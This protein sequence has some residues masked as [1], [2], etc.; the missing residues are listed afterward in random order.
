[1]YNRCPS[2]LMLRV[3]TPLR[4]GVLDTILCDQ[5]CQWLA[6]D[7]WFSPSTLVSFTNKTDCQDIT[8]ILLKVALKHHK[9]KSKPN[10]IQI[11]R[12]VLCNWFINLY[13]LSNLKLCFS[14]QIHLVPCS[15]QTLFI[16]QWFQ[17]RLYIYWR[18]LL[19][20][21]PVDLLGNLTLYKLFL[22]DCLRF[23]YFSFYCKDLF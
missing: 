16:S 9:P 8:E 22:S 2:P 18:L 19:T 4:R 17:Q 1:M 13:L 5:V 6:T 11:Q 23:A 21:Q 20:W 14:F 3:R 7:L 15:W 10:L 12:V